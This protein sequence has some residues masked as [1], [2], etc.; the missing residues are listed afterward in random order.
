MGC[1]RE[2]A[3]EEESVKNFMMVCHCAWCAVVYD[4]LQVD[5]LDDESEYLLSS[6][7]LASFRH[8]HASQKGNTVT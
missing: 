6:F 1:V 3:L 8:C 4:D 7:L 2:L 5:D